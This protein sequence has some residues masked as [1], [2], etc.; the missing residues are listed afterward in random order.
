MKKILF[1]AVLCLLASIT[2]AQKRALREAN[3]EILNE[4]PNIAD[5]RK[6][7]K[8]ALTNPETS[9]LA[10][11]WYL[12]GAVENKQFEIERDKAMTSEITGQK[13]NETVMYPALEA[14][15]PYFKKA[16]ELDQKP[17]EKGKVKPRFTR[18]IKTIL[19]DNRPYYINAGAYYYNQEPSNYE[20]AYE[21]FRAYGDILKLGIY[22]A[23]DIAK[24]NLVDSTETQY[25]YN[26]AMMAHAANKYDAAIEIFNEIKNSGYNEEE[27]YRFLAADYMTV[28]DS[29][30]YDATIIE[31]NKKF[32]NNKEFLFGVI[33][34]D[35]NQ[36]NYDA[37][38]RQLEQAIAA[39]PNEAQY[40]DAL[41]VVYDH[42]KQSDKAVANLKKAV[43]LAP[44]DTGYNFHLGKILFNLGVEALSGDSKDKVKEYCKEALPYFEKVY[45]AEPDNA[46]VIKALYFIYDQLDM[47]AEFAKIE[48]EFK[49]LVQPEQ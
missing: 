14:M 31:G 5:A 36:Q 45:D 48:P 22:D 10:E 26:A 37:P 39:N 32:P 28:G 12:A 49:K 6:A 46:D 35:L 13:P 27:I 7:I 21:N 47:G 1:T 16:I 41:G 18:Y 25:R 24:F 33:N 29:A 23:K 8:E 30:K 3:N 42:A 44:D 11:T 43:E 9:E 19:K 34:I 17:D 2:F 20:K 15:L 4:K 38:I 40:Y